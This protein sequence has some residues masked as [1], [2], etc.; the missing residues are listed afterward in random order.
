MILDPFPSIWDIDPTHHAG[1]LLWQKAN[2]FE[3][4]VNKGLK[5]FWLN[6]SEMFHLISIAW[7]THTSKD[8]T[9]TE[10]ARFSGVTTMSVSKI[11]RKLE[12]MEL[13]IRS[14][15]LDRRSKYIQ[16]TGS[17]IQK[18]IE[19]CDILYIINNNLK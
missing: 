5:T 1:F 16:V 14:E 13:V 17:G 12:N 15:G 3:K 6:Q 7:L 18:L 9:Q 8:I 10:L 4:E 19:T 2:N 11:L